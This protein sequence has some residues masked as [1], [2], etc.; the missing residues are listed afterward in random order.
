MKR[1]YLPVGVLYRGVVF[2]HKDS[3]NKLDSLEM[4]RRTDMSSG[5]KRSRTAVLM[6]LCSAPHW[7]SLERN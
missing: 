3:L 7:E 4:D 5:T 1:S 2:L 6:E